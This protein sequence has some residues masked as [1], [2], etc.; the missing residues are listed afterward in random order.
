MHCQLK[1][2]LKISSDSTLNPNERLW[3]LHAAR[4]R[5][6][7]QF[8]PILL[9]KSDQSLLLLAVSTDSLTEL[10]DNLQ[11]IGQT[12]EKHTRI[13]YSITIS[14]AFSP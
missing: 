2:P 12:L 6:K 11:G 13:I 4:L 5:K 7:A 1:Q 8:F 14:P 9:R 3:S 10:S